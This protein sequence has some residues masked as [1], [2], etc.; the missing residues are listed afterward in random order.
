[1]GNTERWKVP[2]LQ[3]AFIG[4][5]TDGYAATFIGVFE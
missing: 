3:I 4:Y 5:T 1:M 2:I